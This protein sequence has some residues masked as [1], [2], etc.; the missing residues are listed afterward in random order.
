METMHIGVPMLL[1]MENMILDLQYCWESLWFL[2]QTWV[3][4]MLTLFG[5]KFLVQENDFNIPRFRF[6]EVIGL[7]MWTS[8]KLENESSKNILPMKM[9]P[10]FPMECHNVTSLLR[11]L[12]TMRGKNLWAIKFFYGGYVYE[13]PELKGIHLL[14]WIWRAYHS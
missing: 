9:I 8:S 12:S 2:T 7:I 1:T 14:W 10:H 11:K 4:V 6:P 13:N 5:I 3:E